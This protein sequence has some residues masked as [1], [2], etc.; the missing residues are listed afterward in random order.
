MGVFLDSPW[1]GQTFSPPTALDIVTIE[2]AIVAQLQAAIGNV[3]EVTH[4]PDRPENYEMRHRVGVAMV[5]YTGSEYGRL[6]DTGYV[7]QERT[8]QFSVGI[9]IRDLGW[10]FGGP[11]SGTSPGAYQIIEGTRTALTGFQPNTGCTKMHPNRERFIER[12]R[13][14]GM[15]VYEMDFVTRT[16]AVEAYQPPN[17]PLF[18]HGTALEEKGQT[19]SQV[20]IAFFTF[21]GTPGTIT[22]GQGNIS[23]VIVKSQNLAA[24]Y[25]LGTDYTIDN[26][27][28][29]VT[30][31]ATGSIPANATVAISYGYSDI[32][33]ALASGGAAPLNPN[34]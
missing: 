29:I 16:V 4:F 10:A 12:D 28:G 17:Y 31:I 18:T 33:T 3:I 23:A 30:R 1:T 21:S 8:M 6:F 7:A 19:T 20:Q 2:A 5:M 27:N 34:N 14:G 26:V 22:L 9:R 24:T 25:L 13:D 32:V 11:P 15:W